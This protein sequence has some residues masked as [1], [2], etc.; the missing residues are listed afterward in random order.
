MNPVL[1]VMHYKW[2]WA[3]VGS[4]REGGSC[5]GGDVEEGDA[6]LPSLVKVKSNRMQSH[7]EFVITVTQ[8]TNAR[9]RRHRWHFLYNCCSPASCREPMSLWNVCHIRALPLAGCS[10]GERDSGSSG[11]LK[12]CQLQGQY[13]PFKSRPRGHGEQMGRLCW[14]WGESEKGGTVGECVRARA[15]AR[16]C[17]SYETDLRPQATERG[18]GAAR[19]SRHVPEPAAEEAL[20]PLSSLHC[21]RLNDSVL[22]CDALHATPPLTQLLQVLMWPPRSPAAIPLFSRPGS[23][24]LHTH[25]H[26]EA[27]AHSYFHGTPA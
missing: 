21:R 15:A 7:V 11:C 14:P 19:H 13:C 25:L 16:R 24:L 3:T 18:W 6:W 20:L 17:A 23:S 27:V 5:G 12:C 9:T 26:F 1:W 10:V 8:G 4:I 2:L 22:S